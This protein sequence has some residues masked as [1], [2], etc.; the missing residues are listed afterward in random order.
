MNIYFGVNARNPQEFEVVKEVKPECIML[1]YAYWKKRDLGEFLDFI[2][3]RPKVM[4]DSGGFSRDIDTLSYIEYLKKNE[5]YIDWY[6]SPDYLGPVDFP[7]TKEK[8]RYIKNGLFS[9]QKVEHKFIDGDEILGWAQFE[10][11]RTVQEYMRFEDYGLEPPIPVYHYGEHESILEMYI[12][13]FGHPYIA[14]G[15]TVGNL[16]WSKLHKWAN[17]LHD[18]YLADFHMLGSTSKT[19]IQNCPTLYSCD[20]TSW[21]RRANY[22]KTEPPYHLKEP[23]DRGVWWMK[24]IMSYAKE[25]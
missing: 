24:E 22:T 5:Q 15:N 6:I 1:S 18:K 17:Y 2:D 20:S 9:D 19:L 11:E 3:Y 14:L 4:V 13:S 10:A 21:I 16:H 23:V 25:R 8:G 7:F 12:N